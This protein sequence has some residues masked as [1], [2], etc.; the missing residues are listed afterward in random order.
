M[1]QVVLTLAGEQ[2]VFL[3]AT[4]DEAG[5]E[6]EDSH[7]LDETITCRRDVKKNELVFAQFD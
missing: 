6:V 7:L 4:D 2:G 5:D 1:A 3:G